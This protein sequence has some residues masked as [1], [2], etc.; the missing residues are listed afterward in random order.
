MIDAE[1]NPADLAVPIREISRVTGVNTVTLRA[2]ERRYGLLKPTRTSKGHRLYSLE[3]IA[4]VRDIQSWL[5]RGLAIGKVKAVLADQHHESEQAPYENAWQD[6]IGQLTAALHK[7]DRAK[8][9][10]LLGDLLSTYPV[11]AIA[12]QLL[13][14][15]LESLQQARYAN[16]TQREFLCSVLSEKI[17]AEQVR[18]RQGALGRS[19]LLMKLNHEEG[20]ILPLIL[21]YSLL[22]NGY[23]AEY[24]GCLPDEEWIFAAEHLRAELVVIYSDCAYRSGDVLQQHRAW[25]NALQVPVLLSGKITALLTASHGASHGE[26]ARPISTEHFLGESFQQTIAQLGT[27][28][29]ARY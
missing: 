16:R 26:N 22:I 15:V 25:E 28:F 10:A 4:R 29:P 8:L 14:P 20:N 9:N 2:W 23:R 12:D 6:H 18:Q 1:N 17:Y 24:C 27:H 7:L 11:A 13:T 21:N 19:V 5:V 3:D